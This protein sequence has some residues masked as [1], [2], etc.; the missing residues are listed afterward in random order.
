MIKFI[1]T[2]DCHGNLKNLEPFKIVIRKALSEAR[3]HDCPLYIG[4][5]LND[6]K[7]ILRAEFVKFLIEAFL[8]YSDVRVI[9]L[10]GN[11]DLMNHN[12]NTEHSLDFLK[13]LPN[14]LVIDSPREVF[15]GW[16]AIPYYH[17]NEE[18]LEQLAIAKAKGFKK[19]LFHQGIMGA[20][21]SEYILDKS[22]ITLEDLRDFDRVLTGHYHSYQTLNNATYFG[23]PFSVSFA[24]ANQDKF[25]WHV[26]DDGNDIKMT[27]I[28][29]GARRHLQVE[30]LEGMDSTNTIPKHS[31]DDIIKIVAKGSKEF[32]LS[33]NKEDI[34]KQY[35]IENLQVVNEIR[36]SNKKR[37]SASNVHKP[38][39]V[40]GEYL[41][42]SETTLDKT[43]LQNY[44]GGVCDATS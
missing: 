20:K 16:Y 11:H 34:K 42:E 14:L 33:I 36:Q 35:G 44:L 17:R 3:D 4:G 38:M 7:A 41:Q 9:I 25:I 26:E 2:S 32:C 29:P 37:I 22:S 6:T 1:A 28:R 12:D 31:E 5:D 24:E 23:S 43:E 13:S 19:I 10:V 30:W 8:D 15:P 27:P 21:Q 39:E 18:I 40:I